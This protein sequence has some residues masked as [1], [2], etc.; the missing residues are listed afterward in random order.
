MSNHVTD[1]VRLPATASMKSF[2]VERQLFHLLDLQFG[3]AYQRKLS[4]LLST[5]RCKA[6]TTTYPIYLSVL[7]PDNKMINYIKHA[8]CVARWSCHVLHYLCMR[9]AFKQIRIYCYC[10]HYYF[11]VATCVH[12]TVTDVNWLLLQCF[13]VSN[14]IDKSVNAKFSERFLPHFPEWSGGEIHL[15]LVTRVLKETCPEPRIH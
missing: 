8:P 14:T 10:Y 4:N 12:T 1:C 6:K 3:T 13:Y 9:V 11:H 2:K 5:E 7:W 15:V